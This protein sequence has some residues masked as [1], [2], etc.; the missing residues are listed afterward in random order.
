MKPIS[1][2]QGLVLKTKDYKESSSL[3]TIITKDFKQ[4]YIVKGTKK[5]NSKTSKWINFLNNISFN[6]TDTTSLNTLTEAYVINSYTN[7]ILDQTKLEVAFV[8]TEKLELLFEQVTDTNKLYDFTLKILELLNNSSYPRQILQ[9]FEIKI[10]YLLGIAP[11]LNVCMNCE[12]DDENIEFFLDVNLG[13]V[14]CKKCLKYQDINNSKYILSD[15]LTKV[16]KYL[17]YIKID[18]V[19]EEF[20]KLIY[21]IEQ[22]KGEN[23][24]NK[25]IDLSYQQYLDF[26]SKVKKVYLKIKGEK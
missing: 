17:Y 25:I 23:E 5:I 9:L 22:I 26:Y 6:A 16:F 3:V 4:N 21:D 19:D 8:I 10:M 18:N 12:N 13:G 20:L 7:I 24:L 1:K 11:V 2:Y 15:E 14:I